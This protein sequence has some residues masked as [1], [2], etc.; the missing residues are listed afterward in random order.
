MPEPDRFL[1]LYTVSAMV[2]LQR[3]AIYER[4]AAGAFPTLCNLGGNC[5]R[6]LESEVV[7]WMQSRTSYV[8]CP[9]AP[10]RTSTP[11]ASVC[12]VP[13]RLQDGWR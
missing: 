9:A 11:D 4:M 13:C 6:W 2:G 1:P 12:A 5:V 3:S 10:K 7:V 8:P